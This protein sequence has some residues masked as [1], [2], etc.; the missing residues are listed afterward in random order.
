MLLLAFSIL[1][2]ACSG[3]S[4]TGTGGGGSG[5]DGGQGPAGGSG[6]DGGFGGG[7]FGGS[8]SPP[9]IE[10]VVYVPLYDEDTALE[11]PDD[12]HRVADAP[13]LDNMHYTAGPYSVALLFRPYAEDADEPS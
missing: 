11:P 5:G 1:L 6:G 3:E 10:E 8:I 4:G 13:R 7:G 12:M 2:I 9:P